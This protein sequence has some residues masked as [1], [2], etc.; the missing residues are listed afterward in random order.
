MIIRL[1]SPSRG[2][3]EAAENSGA[4]S[5]HEEVGTYQPFLQVSLVTPQN[6]AGA[7]VTQ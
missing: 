7:L 3:R 4:G 1:P 5:F 2:V 6:G